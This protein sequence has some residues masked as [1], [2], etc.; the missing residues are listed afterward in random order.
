MTSKA[1][2]HQDIEAKKH[3]LSKIAHQIGD[4]VDDM[5]DWRNQVQKHPMQSIGIAVG[6][7]VILSGATRPLL[8]MASHQVAPIVR[9]SLVAMLLGYLQNAMGGRSMSRHHLS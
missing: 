3:E 2:L 7:G 5:T 6:M 9:G 4:R 8:R 1:Q